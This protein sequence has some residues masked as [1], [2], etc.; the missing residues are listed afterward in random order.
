M[1]RYYIRDQSGCLAVFGIAFVASGV[2]VLAF[3]LLVDA[4]TLTRAIAATIGVAHLLGGLFTFRNAPFR[5]I[6][7]DPHRRELII[8]SFGWGGRQRQVIAAEDIA[9]GHL[10]PDRDSD[11][12]PIFT[13]RL[14]L[15]SGLWLPLVVVPRQSQEQARADLQLVYRHLLGRALAPGEMEA[16]T[17]E[18]E[19]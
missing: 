6:E 16:P 5:K 15:K 13:P 11:G 8:T 1:K 9:G 18:A 14:R 12:D 17:S 2:F 3:A 10:L 19:G 7:I 4:A